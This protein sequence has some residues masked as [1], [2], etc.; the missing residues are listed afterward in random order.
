MVPVVGAVSV[1]LTGRVVV[2]T[3]ANTEQKDKK[4]FDAFNISD[5]KA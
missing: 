1:I 3:S 4:A 5:K 2:E